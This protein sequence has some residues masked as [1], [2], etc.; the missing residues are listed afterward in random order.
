MLTG[1]SHVPSECS[2]LTWDGIASAIAHELH[3]GLSQAFITV[4]RKHNYKNS[5]INDTTINKIMQGLRTKVKISA[6]ETEYISKLIHRAIT[7]TQNSRRQLQMLN[8]MK[9]NR[10]P[11]SYMTMQQA[12]RLRIGVTIDHRNMNGKFRVATIIN[13]EGTN[14]QMHYDEKSWDEWTDFRIENH[15]F[16]KRESISQR[17]AHRLNA[18]KVGCVIYF[19]PVYLHEHR[20]WKM[21]KIESIDEKSGQVEIEYKYRD[22]YHF[23]WTHLDNTQ[24]IAD[25]A[26]FTN[27]NQ[28]RMCFLLICISF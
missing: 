12:S 14:L 11:F 17:P 28:N 22:K 10:P 27:N 19:N 16:A 3:P 9:S 26:P 18:L 1:R 4:I 23:Y 6:T 2:I 20:G 25:Y 15:R 13:R 8:D 5:Q 21:G 24:E 7:S